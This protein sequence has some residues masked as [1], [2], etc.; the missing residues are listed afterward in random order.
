MKKISLLIL[1]IAFA[2][3]LPACKKAPEVEVTE[4]E[5][6]ASEAATPEVA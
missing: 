4:T 6:A 3:L 5:A 2:L 1:F